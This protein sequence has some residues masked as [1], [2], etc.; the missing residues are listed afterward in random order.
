MSFKLK[1]P[2]VQETWNNA[3]VYGDLDSQ[4]SQSV[5]G[6]SVDVL[7]GFTAKQPRNTWVQWSPTV[8]QLIEVKLSKH[9]IKRKKDGHCLV[10][11]CGRQLIDNTTNHDGG[12]ISPLRGRTLQDIEAITFAGFDV[13]DGPDLPVIIQR[14]KNLGLFAI[15]YTTHS[16]RTV[17]DGRTINKYRILFPLAE[18]FDLHA[19]DKEVNRM[20]C[21]E[22]RARLTEFA[23]SALGI[24]VDESGGDVNRLFYTPRHKPGDKNWFC[25]IFAGRALSFEEMP[26]DPDTVQPRQRRAPSNGGE[27]VAFSGIRPV[28]TDGFDLVD[29][30]RDWG[31]CFKVT[32]LFDYLAW[33]FGKPPC[34]TREG[35]ILCPM[36]ENHSEPDDNQAVWVR[37]GEGS[38]PFVIHCHHASCAAFGTLDRIAALGKECDLP[39][40][41]VTLSELLCDPDLYDWDDGK[42]PNR[43]RY[44]RWD[45]EDA[46]DDALQAVGV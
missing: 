2:E 27:V 45:P 13:D 29:W 24:D 12:T 11:A 30:R 35:R 18:P 44:L 3:V 9:E 32:K 36:D 7:V 37:D 8:A 1:S 46:D 42:E 40:G 4:E 41:Y 28:L 23:R 16:H 15:L 6:Q 39:E 21:A 10:F 5:L 26:F 31:V 22:W 17:K 20:R 34:G 19:N 33:D 38:D 43:E 14:L 25:A